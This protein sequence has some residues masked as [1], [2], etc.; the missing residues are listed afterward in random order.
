MGMVIRK[1]Y[2]AKFLFSVLFYGTAIFIAFGN[3]ANAADYGQL[4]NGRHVKIKGSEVLSI[5]SNPLKLSRNYKTLMGSDTSVELM[6]GDVTP[7]HKVYANTLVGR[8]M[9]DDSDFN[10]NNFH[11][12]IGLFK[13]NQRWS[14]GGEGRFDYDTA[15]T[16]EITTFGVAVPNVRRTGMSISP[17][18]SFA[19]NSI[20]KFSINS[21]LLKS[22]Y[23]NA[24]FTDYKLFSVAPSYSYNFDPNNSGVFIINLQRYQADGGNKARTDNMGPSFGWLSTINQKFSTKITAGIENS[25]QTSNTNLSDKTRINY[26]FSAGAIFKGDQD[27]ASFT[28]SRSQQPFGNGSSS[29]LTSFDV[30]EAYSLNKKVTLNAN[31]NYSFTDYSSQSGTNLDS[32]FRASGGVDYNPL[33][34]LG[35]TTKYQYT[36][37][38]LTGTSARVKEQLV[39]VGIKVS[40]D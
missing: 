16:S 13:S 18:L 32:Q 35:F 25:K 20:E 7:L 27:N 28:A 37:Q 17:Q 5:D 3:H 19:P 24:A 30:S 33:D 8:A 22:K 23:N 31:S 6:L 15:R 14:V 34:E 12:T 4:S 1:L 21:N 39:L 2:A 11:E 9:Y 40:V 36:N 29:L 26:V 38:K 10:A